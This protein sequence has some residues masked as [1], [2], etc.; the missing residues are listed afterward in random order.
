MRR[1][2][3]RCDT[4]A[5]VDSDTGAYVRFEDVAALSASVRSTSS[6]EEQRLRDELTALQAEFE[7]VSA[8]RVQ[9][10]A[11]YA[12]SRDEVLACAPGCMD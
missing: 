10:E 7:S 6:A 5:E 4:G 12:T 8:D 2:Y 9:L 1:F 11:L 3:I